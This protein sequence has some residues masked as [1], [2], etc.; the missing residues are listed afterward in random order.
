[1]PVLLTLTMINV[2]SATVIACVYSQGVLTYNELFNHLLAMYHG[3]YVHFIAY[4]Y[5]YIG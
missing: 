2:V 1:M 3:I 4:I 5:F